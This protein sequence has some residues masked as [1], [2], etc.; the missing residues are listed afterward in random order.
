MCVFVWDNWVHIIRELI[1][2][3]RRGT[4]STDV[5]LS[6][7]AQHETQETASLIITYLSVCP[8]Q[9]PHVTITDVPRW[10]ARNTCKLKHIETLT[11]V[12][13]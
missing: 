8:P 10:Q 7:W 2:W 9:G 1:P 11:G 4:G 5:S 3:K 13:I 6:L 12:G